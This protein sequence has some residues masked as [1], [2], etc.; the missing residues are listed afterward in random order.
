MFPF[1]IVSLA[2]LSA[3]ASAQAVNSARA[4]KPNVV[5]ILTDDQD[6]QLDSLNYMQAVKKHLIQEGT[7]YERHYCTVALCCPSRV[8]LLTGKMAH[9][10]NVTDLR[11]PFGEL[12]VSRNSQH[13]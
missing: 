6:K 7:S 11:L 5:F 2:L 4:G 10:T 13:D 8:N 1:H 9:N 12:T 3:W